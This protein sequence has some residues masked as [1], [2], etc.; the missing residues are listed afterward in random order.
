MGSE[1]NTVSK[2]N[3]VATNGFSQQFFF[4]QSLEY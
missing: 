1:A 4:S 2:I 3:K